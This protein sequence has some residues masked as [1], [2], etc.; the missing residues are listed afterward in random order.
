MIAGETG[1]S[2]PGQNHRPIIGGV[3]IGDRIIRTRLAEHNP[4]A[5]KR[6]SIGIE[7]LQN[8]ITVAGP[9]DHDITIGRTGDF[10]HSVETGIGSELHTVVS[11]ELLAAP[12]H[13]G[14]SDLL[15]GTLTRIQKSEQRVARGVDIEAII[16]R[17]AVALGGDE[18]A[19]MRQ[20]FDSPGTEALNANVVANSRWY[21]RIG[22]KPAHIPSVARERL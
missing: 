6:I 18:R 21:I 4:R 12:V 20:E 22:V 9:G 7:P 14:R 11:P 10:G 16:L 13:L 8:D 3:Q 5:P 1:I 17:G 19:I 2:Y 15:I